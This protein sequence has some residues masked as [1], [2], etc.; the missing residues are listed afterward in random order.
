MLQFTKAT[1]HETVGE[2]LAS[3][4][5]CQKS[6]HHRGVRQKF[7]CKI[8]DK[9]TNLV[10]EYATNQK[11]VFTT[12]TRDMHTLGEGYVECICHTHPKYA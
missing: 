6:M 10:A 4:K 7:L 9:H 1:I 8:Y 2:V 11:G 5:N 12:I 3:S